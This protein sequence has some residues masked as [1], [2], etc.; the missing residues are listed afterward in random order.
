MQG[1][2]TETT[3][4]HHWKQYNTNPRFIALLIDV[5]FITGEIGGV[6]ERGKLE[7]S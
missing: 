4:S 5:G 3:A 1:H 6:P 7:A 2:A